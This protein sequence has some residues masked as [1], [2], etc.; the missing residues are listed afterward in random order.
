MKRLYFV[1]FALGLLVGFLVF[2]SDS[3]ADFLSSLTDKIFSTELSIWTYE[4]YAL[5]IV[6]PIFLIIMLITNLIYKNFLD[7]K[8]MFHMFIVYLIG[9]VVSYVL[10]LMLA[11]MATSQFDFLG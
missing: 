3:V 7:S 1:N 9:F 5:I 2:F 10:F 11:M 4:L 6:I 8:K